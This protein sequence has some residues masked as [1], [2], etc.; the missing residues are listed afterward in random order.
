[1]V[2][3]EKTIIGRVATATFPSEGSG[4]VPV[5][6]DTGADS[7]SIW[8]SQITIDEN[9]VLRF[10]LFDRQSPYYTGTMHVAKH[11]DARLVRSS[12]GLAQVRYSVKLTIVLAGRTVRGTFT[13]AD[14][15]ANTYPVLIGCRLLKNKFLVDVSRGKVVV[16]ARASVGLQAELQQDPRGFYE[17]Y[18]LNNQRGDIEL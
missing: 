13:L 17:K 4:R 15:S 6:I 2:K 3:P 8:A 7:S 10:V 16:S 12:N 18:H 5:K 9:G 14:R 11:Y 1:M